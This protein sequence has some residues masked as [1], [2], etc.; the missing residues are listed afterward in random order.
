VNF[1]GYYK[2]FL[3]SVYIIFIIVFLVIKRKIIFPLQLKIFLLLLF[4]IYVY[5]VLVGIEYLPEFF[6]SL[7]WDSVLI[8]LFLVF[9]NI[10]KTS[11][12][13]IKNSLYVYYFVLINSAVSIISYIAPSTFKFLKGFAYEEISYGYSL[14]G[15]PIPIASLSAM[16]L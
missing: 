4:F 9:Y 6:Y 8:G 16:T 5:T 14:F 1:F 2:D 15:N 11:N 12:S 13:N 3:L 7:I 10:Y